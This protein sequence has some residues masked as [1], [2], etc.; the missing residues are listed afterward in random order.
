VGPSCLAGGKWAREKEL[1][2]KW[3]K[4]EEKDGASGL[5]KGERQK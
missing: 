5:R 1:D 3:R 4:E 2:R